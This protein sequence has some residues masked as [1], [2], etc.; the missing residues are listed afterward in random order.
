MDNN[1]S[2]FFKNEFDN[3][4]NAHFKSSE[5]VTSFFR[6]ILLIYTAPLI[7]FVKDTSL[8]NK[9][10][11]IIFILISL[12][13]FFIVI[14]LIQLRLETILYARTVN[15]MRRYFYD[16]YFQ[17]DYKNS[18]IFYNSLP[19]QKEKPIYFD[20][21]QFGF[22]VIAIGIINTSY[23]IYGFCDLIT[24]NLAWNLITIVLFFSLHIFLFKWLAK[25]QEAGLNF[26]RHR[27]GVDI[28]GVLN[29]H[30]K[31][32]CDTLK[33]VSGID[34]QPNQIKT[35]LVRNS[36]I[37]VSEEDERKVFETESYWKNM[38]IKDGA[39]HELDR[40]NNTL[41]YEIIIFTWRDW[42][43]KKKWNI[44]EITKSW[45]KNNDIIYKD[46][47]FEK[48]NLQYPVTLKKSLYKNRFY[49]SK[50][51]KIKYFIEDD[52]DKALVL[53]NICNKVFL[54]NHKYNE[55]KVLPHNIVRIEKWSEIFDYLKRFN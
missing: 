28:D 51:M 14:Y 33:T 24:N 17:G 47:I 11:D 50:K 2:E 16:N 20:F 12:I 48:G 45:L 30:E 43:Q 13:G 44:E 8:D 25:R 18:Y 29:E 19:V 55:C 6:Y 34:I 36:N 15:G 40:I 26:Y 10:I 52:L 7:L 21:A 22:I 4:A 53:S 35:L 37:G 38:P 42:G 49:L 1:I 41:G 31:H 54:I 5:R 32:F 23:L 3:I 27:I 39:K 46:I 9:S